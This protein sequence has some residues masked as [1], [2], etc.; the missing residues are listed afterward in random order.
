M[1]TSDW[2]PATRSLS[3]PTQTKLSLRT[4]PVW[5]QCFGSRSSCFSFLPSSFFGLAWCT[6]TWTI[7]YVIW[8]LLHLASCGYNEVTVICV[9]GSWYCRARCWELEATLPPPPWLLPPPIHLRLCLGATVHHESLCFSRLLMRL[10][11]WLCPQ[12]HSAQGAS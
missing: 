4:R 2:L 1:D 10:A 7:P 3:H 6:L 11:S 12:R 9:P 8:T 5:T